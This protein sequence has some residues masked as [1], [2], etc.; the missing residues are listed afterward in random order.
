MG[1][2]SD[3]EL[4]YWRTRF[5]VEGGK[6]QNSWYRRLMCSVC[7]QD[8]K[9]FDGKVVC[10][11]G[12]GP[13]GSL[14][15]AN[16]AAK[17]ICADVLVDSYGEL[18]IRDHQAIYVETSEKRIPLLSGYCDIVLTINSLDHVDNLRQ[19]AQ[20][21][22][23]ITKIGGAVAG[24]INLNEPPTPS[25]PQ[26]ITE[27]LFMSVLGSHLNME[28]MIKSPKFSGAEGGGY[29]YLF[30]YTE[31][32]SPLPPLGQEIGYLWFMGWKR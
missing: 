31:K 6:L 26:T 17:R 29:K 14:E 13:R 21:I 7:G 18:G 16:G 22:L 23:R 32:K 3:S 11:F 4:G 12:S 1:K 20:E 9:W 8:E 15:W 5:Q 24:S 25:E 19:M 28:R 27:E 30:D 2:K 10:D